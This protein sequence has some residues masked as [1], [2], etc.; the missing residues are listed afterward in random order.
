MVLL[1]RGKKE[2]GQPEPVW[3]EFSPNRW[4]LA[5]YSDWLSEDFFFCSHVTA[6]S[7]QWHYKMRRRCNSLAMAA[8]NNVLKHWFLILFFK[9]WFGLLC[10]CVS[11]CTFSC[12][13]L[14]PPATVTPCS[15]RDNSWITNV[16]NIFPCKQDKTHNLV[17]STGKAH[18]RPFSVAQHKFPCL[19][20]FSWASQPHSPA[21][22]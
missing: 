2:R 18:D 8:P 15:R 16:I 5:K 9:K 7:C 4:H 6:K 19:D 13:C 21:G 3:G 11:C 1:S 14:W 20:S 17:P 12:L 10:P 22:G